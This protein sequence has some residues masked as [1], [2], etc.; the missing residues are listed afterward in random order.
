MDHI[1]TQVSLRETAVALLDLAMPRRCVVCHRHLT[2]SERFICLPCL[3]DL[4]LTHFWE[5][6]HNGMADKF[7][8]R[9]QE[10]IEGAFPA[11]EP[12]AFAAALIFYNSESEYRRIPWH[13]KYGGGLESGRYFARMLGAHLAA[14]A[15]L[16]DV[17]LVVPVP[18]HWTR[19]LR[20]GYNQAAVIAEALAACFPY[21]PPVRTD[22]LRRTRRTGTQTRVSV[23]GKALN[24]RG[25]FSLR[26]SALD[27][28]P[29]RHILLV[30]DTFTTGATLA[31]CMAALRTAFPPSVR[32][33]VATLAFV[34]ES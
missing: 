27:T 3:S 31:A 32:I 15:H 9:I 33:S 23:E 5:M 1:F 7:N 22:L 25:A 24:V 4:P 26:P 34:K 2:L 28:A 14:S 18:L 8:A 13:L 12:Y 11:G 21:A 20:R 6:T 17:D 30:D 19:R 16:A 29:P 10:D